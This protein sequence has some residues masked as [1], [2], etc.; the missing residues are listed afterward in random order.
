MTE[1]RR[2]QRFT[3]KSGAIVLHSGSIGHITNISLGGLSC[4]C[5]TVDSSPAQH[6]SHLYIYYHDGI[7]SIR[8]EN[9]PFNIVSCG[10]HLGSPLTSMIS[11]SC[12]IQ[13][14]ALSELQS[15]QLGKF[16]SLA[17]EV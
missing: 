11:R 15:E 7:D 4:T 2:H 9:I 16:I 12:G 17:V 6:N 8:V 5:M 13:F 1:R 10:M 14:G 3:P